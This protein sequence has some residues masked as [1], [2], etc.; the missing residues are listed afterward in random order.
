MERNQVRWMV[1]AIIA[2][3]LSIPAG[4]SAVDVAP[5]ISDREVIE[6]LASIRG[7]IKRLD[8]RFEAIDQ[9][10][11]AIDQRFE[12]IDRRF[13][14]M[15]RQIDRRFDE[16]RGFML[17]GFGVTFAGMFSLMGFVL[18]DRRTV[19]AP[20]VAQYRSLEEREERLERALKEIA[21][22]DP[23]AEE[24]LRHAGLL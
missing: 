9:R 4:A 5:R 10:F 12:A 15:E 23:N 14:A 1:L 20:V 16:L 7:D 24:A 11:E 13:E 6:S 2:L 3:R 19:L 22:R 18:W 21:R 17:W 8:Q